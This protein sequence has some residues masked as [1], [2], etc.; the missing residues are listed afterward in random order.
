VN[1]EERGEQQRDGKCEL[2][3]AG[4]RSDVMSMT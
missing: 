1:G 2:H 4:C 3:C